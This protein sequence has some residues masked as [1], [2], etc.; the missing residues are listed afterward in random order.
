MW[1]IQYYSHGF[2]RNFSNGFVSESEAKAL[3]KP[4]QRVTYIN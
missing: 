2:W 1:Y 4:G 3:V